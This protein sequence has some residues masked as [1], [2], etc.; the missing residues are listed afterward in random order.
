MGVFHGV[1]FGAD[2]YF[3]AALSGFDHLIAMSQV[4]AE[5]LVTRGVPV[6]R[7][8][9]LSWGPD[10]N[11]AGFIS[12]PAAGPTAPVVSSGKTGRDIKTL[13]RALAVVRVPA[14][15]Y[16]GVAT[17]GPER[18]P[19]HVEMLTPVPHTDSRQALLTY[20]QTLADL[21]SAVKAG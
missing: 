17:V 20:A 15:V 5:K 3:Q 2:R 11:F 18:V 14:R 9:T 1:P 16:G 7:I 10:M 8:T 12:A 19:S 6:D 4:T 13:L 21:R